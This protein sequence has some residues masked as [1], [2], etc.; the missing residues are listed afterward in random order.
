MDTTC[1]EMDGVST[2]LMMRVAVCGCGVQSEGM[3][4]RARTGGA[5][6]ERER[7]AIAE[8]GQEARGGAGVAVLSAVRSSVGAARRVAKAFRAVAPRKLSQ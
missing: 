3:R 8:G 7:S 2:G 6:R 5:R 4:M 1:D